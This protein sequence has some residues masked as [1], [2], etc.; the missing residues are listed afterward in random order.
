MF[1]INRLRL[2][3]APSAPAGP[4]DE[5]RL[6]GI[7]FAVTLTVKTCP[8]NHEDW[9]RLREAYFVRLRRLGMIRAHWLTEWQRRGVP[10]LH[11]AV[12]FPQEVIDQYASPE[13]FGRV[14][15]LHWSQLAG[16]AYNALPGGQHVTLIWDVVEWNQYVSKHAARGLSHY[17]RN[18]ANIPE[19]WRQI[20]TGR[21]W[22]YLAS[23]A[24]PW[25]LVE[26]SSVDLPM[27]A[28]WALR[29]VVRAYRKA[30]ARVALVSARDPKAAKVARRRISSA[31]GMLKA[32]DPLLSRVR[33]VSEWL[34]QGD[35]LRV[36]ALLAD[37]GHEITA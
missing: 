30:D 2:P 25:P 6:T 11:A 34:P 23:R 35:Q 21:M 31:R 7:G 33:G 4:V 29:R 5:R 22:G 1:Q 9:K 17:Q 28:F 13:A 15:V 27:R 12:W 10:H 3:S 18:P 14:L 19:G 32:H 8:P 16:D 26:P 37:Q 20:G 24:K 36:L